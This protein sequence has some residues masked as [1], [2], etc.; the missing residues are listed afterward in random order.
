MSAWLVPE[1]LAILRFSVTVRFGKTPRPSGTT[2]SPPRT[3][4]SV[5]TPA[6]GWPLMDAAP[7]VGVSCPDMTLRAVDL[8][9][10]FGPSTAQTSPARTVRLMSCSTS[11][12]P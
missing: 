4:R 3:R 10:P 12:P 8:P 6:I 2:Q 7:L 5:G 1:K 9:A 11:M